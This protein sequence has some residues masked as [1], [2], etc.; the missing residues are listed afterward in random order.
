MLRVKVDWGGRTPSYEADL[1]SVISCEAGNGAQESA[2]IIRNDGSF[3]T[4]ALYQ[5]TRLKPEWPIEIKI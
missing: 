1:Y 2:V 4:V 5:I 3:E